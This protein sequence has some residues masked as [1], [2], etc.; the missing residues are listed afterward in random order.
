[1]VASSLIEPAL[2]WLRKGSLD[3]RLAGGTNPQ[4]SPR[5]ARRARQLTSP[6]SR[7]ALAEAIRHLVD[8][9]EHPQA[10]LTSAVPIQREKVL[11]E[12]GLMLGL[13][14]DLESH[15]EAKPGGI[16]LIE[17]LLTDGGSPVYSEGDLGHELARV[18]AA[19]HLS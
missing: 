19:L 18:R 2:V 10:V 16:A 14:A 11:R 4:A 5:L 3:R 15:D 13:A 12:R 8:T 1:M 7:A 9:A 6:R 17:R